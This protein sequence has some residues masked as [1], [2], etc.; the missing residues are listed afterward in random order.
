[1]IDSD[2][3]FRRKLI[4]V[5]RDLFGDIVKQNYNLS[6]KTR[7]LFNNYYTNYLLNEIIFYEKMTKQI[8]LFDVISI[9]EIN[10]IIIEFIDDILLFGIIGGLD[11]IY[12]NHY[13]NNIISRINFVKQI[14]DLRDN[15]LNN[16]SY[17][18][19]GSN[20]NLPDEMLSDESSISI[21]E[22]APE[23]NF[24]LKISENGNS[25]TII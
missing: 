19:T 9:S 13:V 21:N 10:S 16:N 17:P 8:I 14:N 20:N 23:N 15:N 18:D 5:F 12:I 22:E 2:E 3:L 25:V 11:D 4:S 7:N 1:M 24:D 6:G